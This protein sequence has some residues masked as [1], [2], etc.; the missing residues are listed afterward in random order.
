MD[1]KY[2]KGYLHYNDLPWQCREYLPAS[3]NVN[4]ACV[5]RIIA[6]ADQSYL[7]SVFATDTDFTVIIL[8]DQSGTFT[9]ALGGYC[10][11]PGGFSRVV[12]I[13][14][15]I[16]AV[17]KLDATGI[18]RLHLQYLNGGDSSSHLENYLDG[19]APVGDIH[20]D[21]I[22]DDE[23]LYYITEI[24]KR[25]YVRN[26]SAGVEFQTNLEGDGPCLLPKG[27][28][29]GGLYWTCG[30]FL[31]VYYRPESI[32]AD[33]FFAQMS[34]GHVGDDFD[35]DE[36][37][38]AKWA[39]V[40]EGL[41]SSCFAHSDALL[42][43]TQ[44]PSPGSARAEAYYKSL[45]VG[46]IGV[47]IDLNVGAW[48]DVAG[49]QDAGV[50]LE[51]C[52]PDFNT[53]YRIIRGRKPISGGASQEQ[54]LRFE[55]ERDDAVVYE[56]ELYSP[57]DELKIKVERRPGEG[58]GK[59]ICF[60][61]ENQPGMWD[62]WYWQDD[63]GNDAPLIPRI[64]VF[65]DSGQS[66]SGSIDNFAATVSSPAIYRSMPDE[67]PVCA[68]MSPRLFENERTI[69]LGYRGGAG[70][71]LTCEADQGGASEA[72]AKVSEPITSHEVGLGAKIL[73]FVDPVA[74]C[75][76]EDGASVFFGGVGGV[77]QVGAAY[78]DQPVK[79]RQYTTA[80]DHAQ[81]LTW[82]DVQALDYC[83]N[84]FVYG[85]KVS[86]IGGG[87]PYDPYNPYGMS[88][89]GSQ[90]SGGAG[91]IIPDFD[92]PEGQDAFARARNHNEIV[93][94][95]GLPPV[96][97][98]DFLH[99]HVERRI[100]GGLWQR[101]K[102]EGWTMIVTPWDHES[103]VAFLRDEQLGD[104]GAVIQDEGLNA[105]KYEY[106]WVFHDE[107]GNQGYRYPETAYGNYTEYVDAP[108]LSGMTI[109]G[110][111]SPTTQ[112]GVSCVAAGHSGAASLSESGRVY[113]VRFWNEGQSES[114][115]PWRDYDPARGYPHLLGA[116]SG[117]KTVYARGRHCNG[118]E[119]QAVAATIIYNEIEDEAAAGGEF[120][121]VMICYG[122]AAGHNFTGDG[123]DI[124]SASSRE[125]FEPENLLQNDLGAV[126]KSDGLGDFASQGAS[127]E[128]LAEITFDLNV[129]KNI[130]VLGILGHNF[131]Q[132]YDG[133][134]P[135]EDFSVQWQWADDEDFSSG[136]GFVE[137]GELRNQVEILHRPQVTRRWW[138]LK[139][140][141]KTRL[142]HSIT[143]TNLAWTI[144]R[145]VIN[146]Q[147]LCYTPPYNY[148]DAIR[149]EHHDPSSV[150]MTKGRARRVVELSPYRKAELRFK[151]LTA[152]DIGPFETIWS[153][154]RQTRPVLVIIDPASI[155]KGEQSPA[156]PEVGDRPAIYGYL[157]ERLRLD[158]AGW[159]RL[160]L[161]MSVE[162]SVG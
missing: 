105:G 39:I 76:S 88:I 53:V 13:G 141:V 96:I 78:A 152:N 91:Y 1:F 111:V 21:V 43:D 80:W 67:V 92:A 16:Y 121:N 33:G 72:R 18:Y 34:Y 95:T 10:L 134:T 89:I 82:I 74:A 151:S 126:W 122:Q 146:E 160:D 7:F 156:A 125:D 129:E 55:V 161:L 148:D 3:E 62:A 81:P 109:N 131:A 49:T 132:V 41:M 45:C 133:V 12:V 142:V 25:L 71:L 157:G 147:A 59:Q 120:E 113:Q 114:D 101:L 2:T 61:R 40:N 70:F 56:L 17:P 100:N 106:R 138:R 153:R 139:L 35:G 32:D 31:H 110:G 116:G 149:I 9:D 30:P 135:L 93:T 75:V 104:I 98:E 158:G 63:E 154:Q 6:G 115:S 24:D 87:D 65:N 86:A 119:S 42:F 50:S 60:G 127:C 140:S 124:E 22:D 51:L 99:A 29:D 112:R 8:E 123:A 102:V 145:V 19:V 4:D 136:F 107:A 90:G 66:L 137:L 94:G 108:V 54:Y 37:D 14:K 58:G 11:M 103:D 44:A 28:W 73:G 20:G 47:Q 155:S 117:M 5:S 23:F 150:A 68:A 46:N 130:E 15:Y 144:G 143:P 159:N 97:P 79:L 57:P 36:I 52:T 128:Y 38:E 84:G 69:A 118:D 26:I 77:T 83:E 64:V 48:P 162:E 27:R 85:T